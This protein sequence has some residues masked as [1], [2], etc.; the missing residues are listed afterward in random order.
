MDAAAA[1]KLPF[2]QNLKKICLIGYSFLT[3]AHKSQASFNTKVQVNICAGK[4]NQDTKSVFMSFS[5]PARQISLTF[6]LNKDFDFSL[7]SS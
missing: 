3:S 7:K 1:N 4:I 6:G 2:L 5:G